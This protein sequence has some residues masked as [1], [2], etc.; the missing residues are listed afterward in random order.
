MYLFVANV[1][2]YNR[3]IDYNCISFLVLHPGIQTFN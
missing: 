3:Q 1:L 2:S